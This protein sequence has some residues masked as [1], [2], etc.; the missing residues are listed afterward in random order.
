ML[1]FALVSLALV[2]AVPAFAK[3][4][5]YA[6]KMIQI[7]AGDD[8]INAYLVEPQG[9]PK[10]NLVVV[11]EWWGLN[12]WVK[13]TA[14]RFAAQGFRV[15]APDLYRGKVATSEEMAHE[16][17]RGLPDDRAITDIQAA[18]NYL[19]PPS[20]GAKLLKNGVIGFCM[21]GGLALKASLD[22]S[23]F[24]ATVVCYGAPVMSPTSLKKL[25]GPVLGIYGTLDQGITPD[26]VKKFE[27]FGHASGRNVRTMEFDGVGHAFLNDTRPGYKA[28]VALQAWTQIDAFL[29]NNVLKGWKN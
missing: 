11:Q 23:P 12:D 1:R 27:A 9:D 17:M 18:A 29:A 21:G 7:Q 26:D 24:D 13:R 6:G 14:D 10:G 22:Q 4:E 28:D 8:K 19:R 25:R 20:S 2:C 15:L 16:L 5:S 3:T